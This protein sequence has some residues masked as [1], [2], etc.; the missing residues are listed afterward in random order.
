MFVRKYDDEISANLERLLS[1]SIN[2]GFDKGRELGY[3]ECAGIMMEEAILQLDNGY[4]EYADKLKALS[5]KMTDAVGISR[6]KK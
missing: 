6:G 5:V 2:K 1:E 4:V 3:A